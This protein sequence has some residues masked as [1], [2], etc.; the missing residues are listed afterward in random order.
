[1]QHAEPFDT[2]DSPKYIFCDATFT[3]VLYR[4]VTRASCEYGEIA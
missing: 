2:N 1:M 4:G 3:V